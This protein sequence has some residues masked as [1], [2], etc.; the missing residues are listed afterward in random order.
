MRQQSQVMKMRGALFGSVTSAALALLGFLACSNG[1]SQGGPMSS[2]GGSST[3]SGAG[4]G[5]TQGG[6]STSGGGTTNIPGGGNTVQPGG[7]NM[8]VAGGGQGMGV[9]GNGTGGV[10]VPVGEGDLGPAD[11]AQGELDG[12]SNGA[13][14]TFQ[15]VGGTGWYPSR[16][17]PATGPCDVTNANN[18]C[19]TQHQLTT[20]QL[21]PWNE[22]LS[23][24]LRGPMVV[25]QIVAY[26]P[27][28]GDTWARVSAWDSRG[29]SEG[30]AFW[31]NDAQNGFSG[32]V[33]SVCEVEVAPDKP[34]PCGAGS[35]PYCPTGN[36][37]YYGFAGSKLIVVLAWNPHTGTGVVDDVACDGE[38]AGWHDAPWIGLTHGELVR[39]GRYSGCHCWSKPP[40]AYA[41]DGCGQFNVFEVVNDNNSFA[42]FDV[43]S[44]NLV[45]YAGYIGEG[46]CG[47][48]CNATALPATADLLNKQ[49]GGNMA[50]TMGAVSGPGKPTGAAFVRPDQGFRYFVTLLDESTRTVQIAL[51]HP[52]KIPPSVAALLPNFPLEIQ[53]ATIDA[54]VG[55]RLPG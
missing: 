35:V 40:N 4:N 48:G 46:P 34:Y 12:A 47:G 22:E 23:M 38:D 26:Q 3:T 29:T 15:D 6:M 55:L 41:Q 30:L 37:K 36:D 16:R 42:N 9:S 8:T 14:I 32:R 43:F 25:K 7:G 24:T 49:N 13:T 2:A 20:N 17:D 5:T 39:S 53:R 33:G 28:Q 50:A 11:Y 51:V 27:G 54:L 52:S 18:C 1:G 19:M 21:T 31:G 45:S 44:T 10:A